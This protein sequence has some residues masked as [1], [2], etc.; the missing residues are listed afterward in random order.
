[1]N[2]D[3][4][5]YCSDILCTLK[6][7]VFLLLLLF[8]VVLLLLLLFYFILFFVICTIVGLLCQHDFKASKHEHKLAECFY[9]YYWN[10]KWT[11]LNINQWGVFLGEFKHLYSE[12]QNMPKIDRF[13]MVN[14]IE[15]VTVQ[16]M[17]H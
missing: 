7:H 6:M 3:K 10:M 4:F 17:Q 15:N 13:E 2:Y 8:Y 16:A 12:I 1:M 9:Q 5:I 11:A 14:D